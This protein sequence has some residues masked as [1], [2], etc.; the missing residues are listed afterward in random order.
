MPLM[1]RPRAA[2][3]VLLTFIAPL[4]VA[5]PTAA[6]ACTTAVISGRI[7][8][9][10]RPLLWKN[11]DAPNHDNEV[12]RF[13]DGT[14]TCIAVVN[15]GASR[16]IWMGMNEAGLCIE[17]SLSRDL[18]GD[19][20][21][22][23]DGNGE[24][25][26]RA[27]KTCATVGDVEMLLKETDATGRSTTANFGVIDAAGGAVL[28]E[29]GPSSHKKFDANDPVVA[30]HGYVVRSNFSFTA[31]GEAVEAAEDDIPDIYSGERYAR[32]CRLMDRG[33][34]TEGLTPRY[35]LRNCCRDLADSECEAIPGSINSQ[36]AG[37]PNVLNTESTISRTT[38]VSA[39]VF[40]GVKPGEDP[41]LTTMWAILGSPSFSVAVPCWVSTEWVAPEL[42][43]PETSDLCTA[44]LALR[45]AHYA[46]K[47]SVRT[48]RLP[49][50]WSSL[51]KVEDEILND[52][53]RKIADWR[54]S[55]P[56]PKV[57]AEV[58]GQLGRRAYEALY[59]LT[60]TLD[61]EK[62]LLPAASASP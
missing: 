26:L 61:A 52:A 55:P 24:F 57:V 23:G 27:L 4:C 29:T 8:P 31:Q 37:L 16:S 21:A 58:H 22:K 20:N 25:M 56:T 35:L 5:S 18:K 19:G 33:L 60:K 48:D 2:L 11:R 59:E 51:W 44:S 15:A 41:S 28:F 3:C 38:T 45:N 53:E 12:C 13:T 30:P 62:S 47:H 9:D 32:G 36:E 54:V 17:N 6:H 39:A 49:G 10:G 14:F 50:V 46:D 1:R 42:D 43:G 7:T 40:Q 34:R